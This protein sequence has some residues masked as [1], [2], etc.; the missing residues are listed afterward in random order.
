[1]ITDKVNIFS[2]LGLKPR[3]SKSSA[4]SLPFYLFIFLFS[5]TFIINIAFLVP[6][7]YTLTSIL[8]LVGEGI[9]LIVGVEFCLL[10][11]KNPGIVAPLSKDY[12]FK[13]LKDNHPSRICFYC[14][15]FTYL[16][17]L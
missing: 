3:F 7:G 9:G 8:C 4:I 17:R 5:T 2:V 14:D 15:V 6:F 16:Y 11:C 10:C 12:R 13:M 1:M